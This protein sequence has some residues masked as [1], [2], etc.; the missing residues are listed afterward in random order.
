MRPLRP[1]ERTAAEQRAAKIGAAA[2]GT[3][4]DSLRRPLDRGVA[5]IEDSS[6]DEQRQRGLVPGDMQLVA[7]CAVERTAA[8]R[9]DLGVD[10]ELAQERETAAGDR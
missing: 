10:S 1:G 6:L 7:G 4:D 2:A 9:A 5:G 3:A 8:V